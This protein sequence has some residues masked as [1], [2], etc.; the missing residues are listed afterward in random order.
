VLGTV[1]TI[2]VIAVVIVGYW[3]SGVLARAAAIPAADAGDLVEV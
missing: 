3:V 1:E 2:A